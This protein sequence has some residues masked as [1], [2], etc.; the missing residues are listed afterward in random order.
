MF[1]KVKTYCN[2][3][4][5]N[6]PWFDNECRD[7][8]AAFR[9]ISAVYKKSPTDDNRGNVLHAK[10]KYNRAIKKAKGRYAAIERKK[11][12]SKSNVLRR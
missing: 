7:Y 1:G 3:K 5:P 9:N 12:T 11:M 8:K 6:S 10:Q 2:D 4:Y